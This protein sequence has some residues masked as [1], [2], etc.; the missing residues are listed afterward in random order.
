MHAEENGVSV[1]LFGIHMESIE[2]GRRH[3]GSVRPHDANEA[4]I[5]WLSRCT[6]GMRWEIVPTKT[7]GAAASTAV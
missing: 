3:G 4:A 5:S 7:S 1:A 6:I 2:A